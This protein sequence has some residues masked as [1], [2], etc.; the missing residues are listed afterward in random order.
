MRYLLIVLAL[1]A[2][3][4][5]NALA[6]SCNSDNIVSWHASSGVP[7]YDSSIPESQR[8]GTGSTTYYSMQDGFLNINETSLSGSSAIT[9]SDAIEPI[10]PSSDWAF[11]IELRMNSHD[12]P[13]FDTGSGTGVDTESGRRVGFNVARDAIGVPDQVSGLDDWHAGGVYFMDTTDAFHSYRVTKSG[14]TVHIFVDDLPDPVISLPF[15]VFGFGGGGTTRVTLSVTSNPGVANFDVRSFVVN[16]E[17]TSL[18]T[19]D[20]NDNGIPDKCDID[21]GTNSDCDGNKVPD[22]CESDADLDGTIDACDSCPDDPAKVD[23]EIC[24][25]GVSEEDTDQD[26]T[27]D[28]FDAC[29]N[30]PGKT[31]PGPCGCGVAVIDIDQDGTPNCI[32]FCPFDPAKIA[33]GACGCGVRD[34]DSDNDGTPDCNDVCPTDP[35]K[36]SPIICGCGVPDTDTDNDGTADCFDL[37]PVDVNK[38]L[39]GPCDCG[40]PD[41][42]TDEDGAFDCFDECPLDPN[43][44]EPQFCGCGLTEEDVDN[45]GVRDCDDLCLNTT[46]DVQVDLNGCEIILNVFNAPDVPDEIDETDATLGPCGTMGMIPLSFLF[47]GIMSLKLRTRKF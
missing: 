19:S 4:P 43:K 42:D 25:C 24:G 17:G 3:T 29:P 21:S 14:D 45:D 33:A 23:A 31:A 30:D 10:L 9:K 36:I 22:V 1:A 38:T 35:Q 32:D 39:P 47:L 5:T 8:F 34:I 46:V 15:L 37:C 40:V 11:M 18:Q 28:C 12:R 6:Q 44:T 2:L 26:G 7:P 13:G 27:A 41:V 16:T 20:C